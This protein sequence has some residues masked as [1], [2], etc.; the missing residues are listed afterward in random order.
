MIFRS[1]KSKKATRETIKKDLKINEL[2]H[3]MI[4]D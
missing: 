2:E 4:Y 1:E 3:N